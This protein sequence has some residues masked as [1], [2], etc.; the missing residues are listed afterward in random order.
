[1]IFGIDTE[2]KQN[3]ATAERIIMSAFSFSTTDSLSHDGELFNEVK[4]AEAVEKRLSC[5][6]ECPG[7]RLLSGDSICLVPL[8]ILTSSHPPPVCNK[9]EISFAMFSGTLCSDSK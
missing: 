5:R 4:F 2:Y 8:Q 9:T 1:M 3:K 6:S 7:S